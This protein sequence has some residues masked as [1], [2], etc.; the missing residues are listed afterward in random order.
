MSSKKSGLVYLVGAGPGAADLI[1]VKGLRC[2]RKADV[3][4]YDR[5]VSTKLL[6]M[7][8]ADAELIYVGKKPGE[9]TM[10][11]ERMSD[12]LADRASQGAVV[13]RLKGGDPFV[14][15]RGGE[16]AL[17]LSEMGIDFE[18]IPGISSAVAVPAYAGIPVTLRGVAA[19]FTVVTG[20]EDPTKLEGELDWQYLARSRETL[21][22]LMGLGK[23][24]DITKKLLQEGM[25]PELPVALIYRGTEPKQRT[26]I[27][28]LVNIADK[29]DQENFAFPSVI[30]IGK[31]VKMRETLQWFE[32]RLLFGHRIVVSR[33]EEQADLLSSR[34]LELGAEALEYPLIR[35]VPPTDFSELDRAIESIEC[36][37]WLIFTSI[38]GVK[39]FFNRMFNNGFDIRSMAGLKICAIG[40]GTEKAL[41]EKGLKVEYRPEQFRAEAL[42][43]LIKGKIRP[44]DKV[45]LPRADLAR[46][47]LV[48]KLAR[49]GALVDNV[50]AYRTLPGKID[51]ESLK[52]QLANQ[53]IDMITFT[54]SSTVNNLVSLLGSDYEKYL[55][56]VAVAS[57]GP[58]TTATAIKHGISVDCEADFYTI[59]GL[60]E[61]I[62]QYYSGKAGGEYA[63]SAR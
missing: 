27:G 36:Y 46:P 30:V 42:F 59:D 40:P 8:K 29:A 19:G 35:I 63:A 25:N 47:L 53:K 55:R 61:A 28:A 14:F 15:G 21:V 33:A 5:L 9:H 3:I 31:V 2:I 44:G 32:K 20:H 22:I 51:A 45:L 23:L 37:D 62:I 38:N 57:I 10:S 13:V 34:L 12:L 41:K 11:Q 16:E 58:I 50:V 1:T 52:Q 48:E 60:I 7:A 54:S 26:L 17:V 24:R 49:K 56:K 4:V 43:E 39:S 18:I 6:K